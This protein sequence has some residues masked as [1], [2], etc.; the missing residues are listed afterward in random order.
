MADNNKQEL[1]ERADKVLTELR[2]HLWAD[3]GDVQIV[4]INDNN[5]LVLKWQGA[6]TTCKLSHLTL[7]YG[8]KQAVMEQLEEIKDVVV[9]D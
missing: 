7:K 9:A 4:D 1:I 8:I 2:P 5:V 6:C 3:E